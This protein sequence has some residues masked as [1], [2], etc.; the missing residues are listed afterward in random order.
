MLKNDSKLRR[1]HSHYI[2]LNDYEQSAFENYCKKFKIKNKTKF[3]RET[4]FTKILL[5]FDQNYPTLFDNEEM[6]RLE[7]R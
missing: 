6:M 4:L 5:D 2:T 7:Q 1:T 3:I